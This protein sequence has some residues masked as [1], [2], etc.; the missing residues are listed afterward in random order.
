[1]TFC[2]RRIS[3]GN[4]GG[5]T[6]TRTRGRCR[7]RKCVCVCVC[8]CDGGHVSALGRESGDRPGATSRV[9]PCLILG[10][11]LGDTEPDNNRLSAGK[12]LAAKQC[13]QGC[14]Q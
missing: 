1:M 6:A 5:G 9:K 3:T 14:E 4:G 12:Q 2:T 11:V 7:I 8:V 13:C 10:H